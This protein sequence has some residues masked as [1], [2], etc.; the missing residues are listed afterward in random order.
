MF[1]II[2]GGGARTTDGG[3]VLRL[4]GAEVDDGPF[5]C[6]FYSCDE[7]QNE[8]EQVVPNTYTFSLALP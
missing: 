8:M 1:S 5:G 7:S 3:D 2:F 6:L 4:E